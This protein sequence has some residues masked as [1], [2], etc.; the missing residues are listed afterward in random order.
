[1]CA[2]RYW[3]DRA[4][5]RPRRRARPLR[6]RG[7]R[8]RRG[9]SRPRAAGRAARRAF[10][11]RCGRRCRSC[12][13]PGTARSG[14]S[15]GRATLP[16][17]P[18]RREPQPTSQAVQKMPRVSSP[19]PFHHAIASASRKLSN[20]AVRSRYWRASAG[21]SAVRRNSSWLRCRTAGSFS[22]NKSFVAHGLRLRMRHGD[23]AALALV[24]VEHA[25]VGLVARDGDEL[26]GEIDRVVNAR[27]HAHGADRAVHMGGIA[28]QDGAA[29]AEFLRHPL[30][31]DVK[32]AADDVERLAGRQETLAALPATLPAAS[33]RSHRRADRSGNARASGPAGLSSETDST[34]PSDRKCNCARHSRAGGNRRRLRCS[35]CG[36]RR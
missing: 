33:V 2:S 17:A 34:I 22:A 11:P 19:P 27:V 13:R 31:H 5:S 28:R 23:M 7:C 24:A 35:A 25:V 21:S 4:C 14:G 9:G 3:Q 12:C 29:D 15:A 16:I 6:C 30:V 20:S 18:R 32:I 10:A 36:R 26:V 8:W 1:M